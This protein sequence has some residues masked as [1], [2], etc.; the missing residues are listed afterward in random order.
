[1]ADCFTDGF[2]SSNKLAKANTS[3]SLLVVVDGF[4]CLYSGCNEF[5]DKLAIVGVPIF[6]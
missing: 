2:I 1:M 4:P 6:L 5:F 3:S